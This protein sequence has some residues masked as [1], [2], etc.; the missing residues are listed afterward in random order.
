MVSY[1]II[2]PLVPVAVFGVIQTKLLLVIIILFF[3]FGGLHKLDGTK[4]WHV[5]KINKKHLKSFF[6][7]IS[8]VILHNI[9]FY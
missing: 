6:L 5:K 2:L 3:I 8:P 4:S 7:S 1:L 9:D